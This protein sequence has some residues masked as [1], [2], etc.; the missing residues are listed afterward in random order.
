[1]P[2]DKYQ[3]VFGADT[4]YKSGR[5]INFYYISQGGGYVDHSWQTNAQVSFGP[6]DGRWSLAAFIR[7]IEDNRVPTFGGPTPLL[8]FTVVGTTPPRT[9]GGRASVKL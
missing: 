3:I 7:N 5:Y 1:M 2:L 8:N 4:Q 6:A 9:F